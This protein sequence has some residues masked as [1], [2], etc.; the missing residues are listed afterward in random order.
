MPSATTN[1]GERASSE[2]SLARRWRPVSVP[3]YCSATRSTSVDLEG[4]FAVADP[5]AIAGMQRPRR[6]QHLL[7]EVGAVRRAEILDHDSIALLEDPRVARGGERILQ[8]DLRLLAAAE[9][10][11]A[12]DVVDHPRLVPRSALDDE[13]RRA[14]RDVRA[15]RAGGV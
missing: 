1:S 10:E 12:V 11:I 7:V 3:A 6:L 4:E 13:L 8:T 15:G 9:H 14:V 5:H 2:S